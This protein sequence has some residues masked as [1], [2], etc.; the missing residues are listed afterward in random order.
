MPER[1]ARRARKEAI[2]T[3]PQTDPSLQTDSHAVFVDRAQ[4]LAALCILIHMNHIERAVLTRH[5]QHTD[6][7][8]QRK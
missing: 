7:L 4:E 8:R 6:R 1:A 2:H 3:Q 5:H